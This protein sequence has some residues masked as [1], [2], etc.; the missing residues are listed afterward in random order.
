MMEDKIA[1]I[2]HKYISPL[3]S[4]INVVAMDTELSELFEAELD[5]QKAIYEMRILL[6][7]KAKNKEISVLRNTI[8][9]IGL[10]KEGE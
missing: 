6:I 1:K 2:T 4:D 10:T 5:T 8:G 7:E 3:R 9:E